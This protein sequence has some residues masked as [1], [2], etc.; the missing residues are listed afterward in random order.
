MALTGPRTAELG[1]SAAVRRIRLPIVL[2]TGKM[3]G[4][5]TCF[6]ISL[7]TSSEKAPACVLVPINT[8]GFTLFTTSSRPVS[9]PPQSSSCLMNFFSISSRI[10]SPSDA[11]I[12][13]CLS[14]K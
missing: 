2:L 1:C 11:L 7:M 5:S 4:R 12:S 13:P 3:I 6:D 10:L 8:V 9:S 14:I